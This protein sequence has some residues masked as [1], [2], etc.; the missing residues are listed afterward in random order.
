LFLAIESFAWM[1]ADPHFANPLLHSMPLARIASVPGEN[2][3]KQ[4]KQENSHQD[5]HVNHQNGIA[6]AHNAPVLSAG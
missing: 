2:L 6:V 3:G 1:H 5:G 4:S